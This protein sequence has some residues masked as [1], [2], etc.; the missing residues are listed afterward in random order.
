VTVVVV[1]IT[2]KEITTRTA[3]RGK[4][5]PQTMVSISTGAESTMALGGFSRAGS[6]SRGRRKSARSGDWMQTPCIRSRVSHIARPG[7]RK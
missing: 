2:D 7:S 6:A 5:R 4:D 1:D 3:I